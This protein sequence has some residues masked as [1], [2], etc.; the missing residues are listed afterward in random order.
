MGLFYLGLITIII[1]VM[2]DLDNKELVERQNDLR[3]FG[4]RIRELRKKSKL[5]QS[6]LAEKIGLSTNFIGMVER[7][8]RNTSVDKIFKLSRAFNLSL[9]EFF[10]TL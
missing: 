9:A 4:L 8:E 7:G 3:I 5:T 1:T 10:K 6:E 2:S